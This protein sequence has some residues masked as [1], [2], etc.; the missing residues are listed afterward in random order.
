VGRREPH[1]LVRWFQWAGGPIDLTAVAGACQDLAVTLDEAL[2]DSPEKT[3][4]LR[5][6][7]EARECFLRAVIETREGAGRTP[8]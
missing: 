3:A 2:G 1:R 4:G 7:L 8:A 6:L 5:K